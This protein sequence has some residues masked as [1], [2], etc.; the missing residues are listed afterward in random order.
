M[1]GNTFRYTET[2]P[3]GLAGG[4]QVIVAL[5]RGGVY[6]QGS[7][8]EFGESYLKFLLRFLGNESHVR[9]DNRHPRRSSLQHRD[10]SGVVQRRH[11]EDVRHPLERD[12][13]VSR[14]L[15]WIKAQA[16]K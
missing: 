7:P 12:Q 14:A 13:A 1:A 4:K 5:S 9:P 6:E 8:A 15:A 16:A 11:H 10:G 2:G 3:Q